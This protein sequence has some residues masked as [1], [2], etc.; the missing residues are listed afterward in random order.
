MF[1][2]SVSL[3][4]VY[5]CKFYVN[6]VFCIALGIRVLIHRGMSH[7]V[8]GWRNCV[9]TLLVLNDLRQLISFLIIY[10]S[11][12]SSAIVQYCFYINGLFSACSRNDTMPSTPTTPPLSSTDPSSPLSP[13]SA[14]FTTS[15]GKARFLTRYSRDV[16]DEDI[17]NG[18]DNSTRSNNTNN[19]NDSLDLRQKKVCSFICFLWPWKLKNYRLIIKIRRLWIWVIF[20]TQ[21]FLG[22]KWNFGLKTIS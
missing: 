13:T 18:S 6:I 14:Y 17:S 8:A 1:P 10:R 12:P 16:T 21:H 19:A 22:R 11:S 2:A 9:N 3:G 5:V 20:I 4:F 7:R 15:E